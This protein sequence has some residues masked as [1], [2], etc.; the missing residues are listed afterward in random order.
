MQQDGNGG[1]SKAE[2]RRAIKGMG[3][4]APT[5]DIDALFVSLQG[6]NR[7]KSDMD[8]Y[9]EIEELHKAL[10]SHVRGSKHARAPPPL[11]PPVEMPLQA[12]AKLDLL[13]FAQLARSREGDELDDEHIKLMF[14][15]FDEDGNGTVS[16]HE[17]LEYSLREA[18]VQTGKRMVELFKSWDEDKGGTVSEKE[19][20]RAVKMLGFAVPD[21]VASSM[22]KKLDADGNGLLK[23]VSEI[24]S[25]CF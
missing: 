2:F 9:L 20:K 1:I 14:A 25:G 23:C 17:Y 21:K 6:E 18:C 15:A 24:A 12:D 4:A 19:F 22:Y 11:P 3:Y 13:A 7:G 5:A 16:A 10:H 8:E